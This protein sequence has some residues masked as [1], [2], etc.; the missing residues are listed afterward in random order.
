MNDTEDGLNLKLRVSGFGRDDFLEIGDVRILRIADAGPSGRTKAVSARRITAREGSVREV[1]RGEDAVV[2]RSDAYA[3]AHA[4][5]EVPRILPEEHLAFTLRATRPDGAKTG[6][7]G[8]ML[9]R[10][11]KGGWEPGPQLL[12]NRR[13]S[14]KGWDG[15][16][17]SVSG[18]QLG[19]KSGKYLLILFKMKNTDAV[20]VSSVSWTC[21]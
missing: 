14:A 21:R 3:F 1:V 6:L 2:C 4:V 20:A 18:A 13:L 19:K 16:E 9:Y 7:L 15:V 5:V 12:W 10:H 11:K 8:A 17:F